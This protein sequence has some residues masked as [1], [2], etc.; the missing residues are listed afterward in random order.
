ME[1]YVRF[2]TAHQLSAKHQ[3]A[4]FDRFILYNKFLTRRRGRRDMS[5]L[6]DL[7][8]DND[9]VVVVGKLVRPVTIVGSGF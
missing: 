7:R 3:L 6:G 8:L 5:E 9:G 4:D 2:N 1:E